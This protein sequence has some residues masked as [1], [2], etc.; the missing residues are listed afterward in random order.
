MIPGAKK[1]KSGIITTLRL[2]YQRV[3]T[4]STLFR[5]GIQFPHDPPQQNLF[6][7]GPRD[8]PP[9]ADKTHVFCPVCPPA[10]H[11]RLRTY[12]K[13]RGFGPLT[14]P[15]IYFFDTLRYNNH[16]VVIIPFQNQEKKINLPCSRQKGGF[17][18]RRCLSGE[19][20]LGSI[21]A[22]DLPSGKPDALKD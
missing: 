8:A 3:S 12:P 7:W 19:W 4:K 18:V 15:K 9:G 14:I 17:T 5:G 20:S 6:C 13:L 11:V 2:L 10:A 16:F 21:E 22:S 1:P